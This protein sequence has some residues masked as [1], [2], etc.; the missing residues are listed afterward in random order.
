[1]KII[2]AGVGKAGVLLVRKL[3]AEG[4]E[5]VV[6]D[7]DQQVLDDC[8][9]RYD[10]MSVRG[11]CASME[12]L[13]MA[14]IKSADVLV[15]VSGEDEHNL[16]CCITAHAMNR[17]VDTVARLR[18]PEYGNQIYKLRDVYA[19]TM[20]VNPER[21]TA[22]E[23]ERM[24]KFPGFLRRDS[25][26]KGRAEMVELMV[27][28]DGNLC[29]IALSNLHSIIRSKVLVCGVRRDG[30]INTPDGNFVLEEGDRI[31][32]TGTSDQLSR[33][34]KHLG[35]ITHKVRS[36]LICGGGR[37]S[38]YLAEK[39]IESGIDVHII[40][41]DFER[42]EELSEKLPK[43]TIIH[44][45]ASNQS[46]LES[47]GIERCDAVVAMTDFDEMNMIISLY[48]KNY[49]IENVVTRVEHTDSTKLQDTLGLGTVVCPKEFCASQIVTHIRALKNATGAEL[50]LHSFADGQ[51]QAYEY[52]VEEDTLHVG[53]PL[54]SLKLRK[55]V[56]IACITTGRN[57]EIPS[58]ESTFNV[59]DG[60]VVVTNGDVVLEKLNDIFD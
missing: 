32:V 9:N 7:T 26:A 47:E 6:I 52:R 41:K 40:E 51:M 25:F 22:L 5:I 48:A 27:K 21:Q 50:S 33:M 19:L 36:V 53:E 4:Y 49:G 45:D 8:S 55:N 12:V 10:V 38:F 14:G 2:I 54:R 31:Y 15:A 57:A 42:C 44:G 11:N 58:G 29:N 13:E 30:V 35:V 1:M 37:P 43:A 24:L 46:F 3:L 60:L 28:E 56:I 39:L 18:S 20:S 16:L 59:G 23:I 34:L 17:K